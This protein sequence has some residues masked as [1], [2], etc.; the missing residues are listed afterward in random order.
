MPKNLLHTALLL[1]WSEMALP[2]LMGLP[3]HPLGL[4]AGLARRRGIHREL[5]ARYVRI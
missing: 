2:G 5:A 3:A 1:E 4:L